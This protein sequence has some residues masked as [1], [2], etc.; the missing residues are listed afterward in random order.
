MYNWGFAIY[1]ICY[2]AK[3]K[4]R[5]ARISQQE[6]M[7]TQWLVLITVAFSVCKSPPEKHELSLWQTNVA[8]DADKNNSS[9]M[10]VIYLLEQS[11]VVL[12][13]TWKDSVQN[14]AAIYRPPIE[15]HPARSCL[16]AHAWTTNVWLSPKTMS[17]PCASRGLWWCGVLY[18]RTRR[19]RW[20]FSVCDL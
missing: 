5:A 11:R 15:M 9:D 14:D 17:W 18:S 2:Y 16:S 1:F 8:I 20:S 3:M 12:R 10:E 6:N 4:S 7:T 19:S 13:T